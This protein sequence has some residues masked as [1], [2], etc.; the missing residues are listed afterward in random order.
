MATVA[1]NWSASTLNSVNALIAKIKP[2]KWLSGSGHDVLT[3]IDLL[4]ADGGNKDDIIAKITAIGKQ[5]KWDMPNMN[6]TTEAGF[7]TWIVTTRIEQ[8]KVK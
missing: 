6:S 2:A 3:V 7:L 1:K 4:I 8:L 5:W